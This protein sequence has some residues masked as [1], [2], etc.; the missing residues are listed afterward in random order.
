FEKVL[1]FGGEVSGEHGIGITK[2]GFLAEEKISALASY[3]RKVDPNDTLNPGKLTV[4]KLPA[5][6]FTFSFNRLI[7]D[8]EETALKDKEALSLLLKNVQ[9]CT[10]CGKCK[11]VC[12]MYYPEQGLL[13]HPRNKNISLGA[14]IEAVYYSQMQLGEPEKRLLDELRKLMEHCTGC[15]KCTVVCPVKIDSAGC[16]IQIRAFLDYKGSGGHPIKQK[17]LSHLAQD[18]CNRI[19]RMA[20]GLSLGQSIANKSVGLIPGFWRRR[21]DSPVMQGTGPKLDFTNLYQDL[22]LYER[23][24]FKVEGAPAESTALYFPGCGA[25]LFSRSIGMATLYLL[26]RSRV[27][28]VMPSKHLCC[29]Y[30]LL[31]AGALEAYKTNRH[32]THQDMLDALIACGKSGLMATMLITACGTCRESLE[33]FDFSNDLVDPLV[34]MD[35]VQ[36][37]HELGDVKFETDV[38]PLY[39]PACHTEWTGQ[40]KTKAPELYATAIEDLTGQIV[41]LSPGCCAE[42]GTGAVSSPTIYNKLRE[43]KKNQLR[44]DLD[45]SKE[46]R[47]V[48]VGCPSCKTGVQRCVRQIGR[49]NPVMHTVEFLAEQMG[50]KHWQ[51]D[52]R[53]ML[54]TGKAK[55]IS[56]T[57]EL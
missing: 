45:G 54:A 34:H 50:G 21:M 24:V 55:G 2:I 18:P 40:I 46:T 41:D 17:V 25:A 44:V 56:V 8:L 16:A 29:G 12:P 10:R 49:K 7:H 51:K 30:P 11:Q 43:R 23:S 53:R 47:P 38:S 26:L 39:H 36:L 27:N 14:L 9:T 35:V 3:K 19:P 5:Q 57:V 42:S 1:S 28:V 20:K 4:R 48:L 15:G 52:L 6:P 22:K 32:R 31:S 33:S 13:Y 37:I